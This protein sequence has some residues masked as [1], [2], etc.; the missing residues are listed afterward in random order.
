MGQYGSITYFTEE[1]LGEPKEILR[2]VIRNCSPEIVDLVQRQ[3]ECEEWEMFS[4]ALAA[5]DEDED[6]DEEHFASS[7]WEALTKTLPMSVVDYYQSKY[8]LFVS[9]GGSSPIA[10][11]VYD[12][13]LGLPE[14]VRGDFNPWELTVMLGQH[15]LFSTADDPHPRL[16]GNASFSLSISGQGTPSNWDEYRR[17]VWQL[18]AVVE[19]SRRLASVVP[20]LKKCALWHV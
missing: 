18:P 12:D 6:E 2:S 8:V 15:D 13:N 1:G 11:Q 14:S 5:E 20:S 3:P 10:R 17:L 19:L 4:N 9:F 16:I 7:T